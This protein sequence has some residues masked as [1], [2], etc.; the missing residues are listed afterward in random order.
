MLLT[1]LSACSDKKSPKEVVDEVKIE[2]LKAEKFKLTGRYLFEKIPEPLE[3][4]EIPTSTSDNQATLDIDDFTAMKTMGVKIAFDDDQKSYT[5]PDNISLTRLQQVTIIDF[6]GEPLH[7]IPAWLVK[8][9]NLKKLDLSNSY[10]P[11]KDIANIPNAPN[12]EILNLSNNHFFLE[13]YNDDSFEGMYLWLNFLKKIQ[14]VRILDLSNT[15]NKEKYIPANLNYLPNLL[16]LNLMGNNV[17]YNLS[18]L[19]LNELENLTKLNL[20]DTSLKNSDVMKYLPRE[21]LVE[22]DLSHN[23]LEYLNFHGGVPN[24]QLLNLQG[25]HYLKMASEYEGAFHT[26]NLVQLVY[27]SSATI[28]EGLVKRLKKLRGDDKSTN[29]DNEFIDQDDSKK[30]SVNNR[31]AVYIDKKMGIMWDRCSIG[32]VWQNNTCEGKATGYMWGKALQAIQQLNDSN[33]LGYNDWRLPTMEELYS[34]TYCSTGFYKTTTI[35]SRSGGKKEVRHICVGSDFQK[36]TIDQ[37]VFPNTEFGFY[38]SHIEADPA[39]NAWGVAFTDGSSA[40][41]VKIFP[42]YVRPVRSLD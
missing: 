12:L 38:W 39:F 35:P 37:I 13:K 42:F 23:R 17:Q 27:D 24:L 14:N 19:G 3:N 6:N 8:F 11:L 2:E 25:N 30:I 28:P 7:E 36:P 29:I 21:N 4:L 15:E 31:E 5:I 22:L 32:Q 1:G 9:T 41:V 20:Q 40:Y 16:E 10:A 33:Y 26:K 18:E 34:L